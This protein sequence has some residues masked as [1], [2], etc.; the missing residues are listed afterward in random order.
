MVNS[1]NSASS[2]SAYALQIK[3]TAWREEML[4]QAP[5]KVREVAPTLQPQKTAAAASFPSKGGFLDVFA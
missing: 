3:R 5:S 4:A 2:S 1:I